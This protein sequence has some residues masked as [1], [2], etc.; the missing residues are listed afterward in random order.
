M[1][2]PHHKGAQLREELDGLKVQRFP[3][4]LPKKHQRLCY[5]G[6][7]LP[8]LKA[9]HLAR[10]QLPLLLWSELYNTIRAARQGR[11]DL[12][13]AHWMVPSGLVGAFCKRILHKPLVISVHA[14]DI[15]PLKSRYLKF[16]GKVALGSC[17]ACTCNSSFTRDAVQSIAHIDA[18]T[19]IIPMGVDLEIFAPPNGE[20]QTDRQSQ[21]SHATILSVGR[22]V[23]KKGTRYLLEAMPLVKKEVPHARL[24]IVGDGPEKGRM[25]ELTGKLGLDDYVIFTGPVANSEL[26]DLYRD[27]DVFVLPSVVDSAGDTEGLGVVLLEA[28]ACGTPVIGSNVGGI[29]DIIDSGQN[30]FLVEQRNPQELASGIIELLSDRELSHRFS[31]NGIETVKGRF[32]WDRVAEDFLKVYQQVKR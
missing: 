8:N 23:E 27:A 1:L 11:V 16:A 32:S 14:G 15:F 4:F 10:I 21:G 20:R 17:D 7:I 28:M 6:G 13:H 2:S 26:P 9:S 29:P 19:Q 31:K 3:Y 12:I 5:D 25:K 30:G 22:L 18:R 24:V